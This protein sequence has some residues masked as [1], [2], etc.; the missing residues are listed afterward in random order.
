MALYQDT[1]A[2]KWG[3]PYLTRAAFD[4]LHE[5]MRDDIL[6]IFAMRNGTPIAG[7]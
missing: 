6:L 2:R 4:R 3:T 1:G 7:R 5:T